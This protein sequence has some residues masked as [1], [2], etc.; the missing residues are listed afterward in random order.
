[1]IHFAIFNVVHICKSFTMKFDKPV[2]NKCK[3]NNFPPHPTYGFAPLAN[4]PELTLG[5]LYKNI[6]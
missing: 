1:M 4:K 3:H 6:P 5:K 2:A